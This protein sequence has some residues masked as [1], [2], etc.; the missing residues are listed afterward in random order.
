M[1]VEVTVVSVAAGDVAA[2]VDAVEPLPWEPVV[3]TPR[4]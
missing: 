2:K 1:V 3:P 4:W